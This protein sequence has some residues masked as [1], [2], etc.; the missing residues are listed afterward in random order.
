MRFDAR[1]R[2][3]CDARAGKDTSLAAKGPH[4]SFAATRPGSGGA[5][6]RARAL[7]GPASLRQEV[8]HDGS[9]SIGRAAPASRIEPTTI[10]RLPAISSQAVSAAASVADFSGLNT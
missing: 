7:P 4:R 8:V 2:P 5:A 9:D 6:S 3:G 10:A 1:R